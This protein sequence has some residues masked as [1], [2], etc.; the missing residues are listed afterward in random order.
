MASGATKTETLANIRQIV[1]ERD[2]GDFGPKG[3]GALAYPLDTGTVQ[4]IGGG[5]ASMERCWALTV[6]EDLLS[7]SSPSTG[8]YLPNSY[9]QLCLHPRLYCTQWKSVA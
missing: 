4:Y 6:S 2:T 7:S 1:G 9:S 5:L 3:N 8:V